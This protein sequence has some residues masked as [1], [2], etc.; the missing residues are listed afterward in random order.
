MLTTVVAHL[1]CVPAKDMSSLLV[2]T[3]FWDVVCTN[4]GVGGLFFHSPSHSVLLYATR[5]IN[6]VWHLCSQF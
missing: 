5:K 2:N 4:K 6:G 1:D 3:L